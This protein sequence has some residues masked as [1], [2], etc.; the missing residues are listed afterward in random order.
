MTL[1]TSAQEFSV[2]FPTRPICWE[3]ISGYPS[4]N[5]GV[6]LTTVGCFWN[7]KDAEAAISGSHYSKTVYRNVGFAWDEVHP[8]D[9]R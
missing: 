3:A 5:G 9:V 4:R 1:N 2:D 7:R 8:C 6:K